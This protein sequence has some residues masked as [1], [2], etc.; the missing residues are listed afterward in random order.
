MHPVPT[1]YGMTIGEYG[2]MI[3]GEK[4]LKNDIQC[5][6]TVISLRNYTHNSEYDLPIIPSPNLPNSKSIN[7]YASLCL[8]E[9]TNVSAGRGTEM[10]FQIFG[11]PFL[12]KDYF[13]F[14]FT[15]QPNFG[16]KHPKHNGE[17]CFGKD[18]RNNKKLSELNLN[19][20]IEAYNN[21]DNKDVFF[22]KFFLKLAG[23]K[24]LQKQIEQGVSF[25]EIKESWQAD[26]KTFKETR[27]KYIIYE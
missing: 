7:L 3:N 10:Q 5:D 25:E 13:D 14:S 17:I 16:A 4:W 8:F 2:K 20:L 19:W 22:N 15:P 12:S 11:S 1:V 24:K 23:T 21:T 6:L 27:K 9:G 26:L 18:L